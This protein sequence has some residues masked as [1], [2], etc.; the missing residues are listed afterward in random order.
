M[1]KETNQTV[2]RIAAGVGYETVEHFNRLFKKT[3]GMTPMQYR[4]EKREGQ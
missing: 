1:L 3:Y 4:R 2:E